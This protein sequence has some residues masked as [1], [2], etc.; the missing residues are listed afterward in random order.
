[1]SHQLKHSD[2]AFMYSTTKDVY[3]AYKATWVAWGGA[4]A[5][6]VKDAHEVGI[7]YAASMWTLTAGA[8][9]IHKRSDF[10]S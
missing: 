3:R 2:V 1:M 7:H 10:F 6:A 9:N 4:S 8:E 5:D